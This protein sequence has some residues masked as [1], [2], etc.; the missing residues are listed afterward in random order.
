[1]AKQLIEIKKEN[2]FHGGFSLRLRCER[3]H[4]GGFSLSN[5]QISKLKKAACPRTD[6]QCRSWASFSIESA[7]KK[8]KC[9]RMGLVG[10]RIEFI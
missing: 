6:C 2:T 3:D 4:D 9:G 7:A 8:Y 10:N 1:M 5:R